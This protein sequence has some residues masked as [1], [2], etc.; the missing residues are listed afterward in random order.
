MGQRAKIKSGAMVNKKIE[1][2]FILRSQSEIWERIKRISKSNKI[3]SAYLFSGPSGCGKEGTAIRFAQLLNCESNN[4]IICGNCSSCFR[5]ASLRHENIKIV[6]P[7]PVSTNKNKSQNVSFN[8]DINNIIAD[9]ILQKSIDY[10][11]KIR[12]PMANR[13]L[14]HSIR[15]LRKSLYLKSTSKGIKVVL[16]FDA[17]LLSAGQ[18]EAAN[19]L[20]KLLEEPPPGTTFVLVTDYSELL[21]PTII[22]RCQRIGF[23][24][25]EDVHVESWL[26]SKMI[27]I[28]HVP[29]LV[30]LSRGN[31]H[32]AKFFISQSTDDLIEL[33]NSLIDVITNVK[34]DSWRKFILDYS[35]LAKQEKDKFEY[36]MM[37]I[38]I[39]FHSV[40]KLKNSIDDSLHNTSLKLKM[41][42][43]IVKYSSVDF[44]SIIFDLEQIVRATSMNLHMPL[45]LTNFLLNTKKNLKK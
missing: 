32:N 3:G 35:R 5:S 11:H 38:K 37:L 9:S 39:W 17:H 25:L 8:K 36:H 34:S 24:C 45:V 43:F 13:I 7:L 6:F 21:L 20:L 28:A 19:A 16:I 18:G 26:N 42:K 12:I 27:K 1:D 15:E 2:T 4:N 41:E 30:G 10:F 23:P 31:M 40:Y 22:S 29:F 44:L 33:I 14:I